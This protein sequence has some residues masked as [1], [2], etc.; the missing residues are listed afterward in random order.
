MRSLMPG[1]KPESALS[2][3]SATRTHG[4]GV[5]NKRPQLATDSGYRSQSAPPGKHSCL[6]AT[7]V[8]RKTK[9]ANLT[10]FFSS[11]ANA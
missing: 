2:Q 11:V 6:K 3:R 1:R 7:H 10:D 4:H 9:L 5:D 8:D